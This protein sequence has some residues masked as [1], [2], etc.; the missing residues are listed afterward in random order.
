MNVWSYRCSFLEYPLCKVKFIAVTN[1]HKA[2][3]KLFSSHYFQLVPSSTKSC[4]N[5]HLTFV[6]V[7]INDTGICESY[8][9]VFS[10]QKQKGG[11][12]RNCFNLAVELSTLT[13]VGVPLELSY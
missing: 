1:L 4:S 6:V 8:K 3:K 13:Y 7:I 2:V 12:F 11:G 9:D 5:L 10:C